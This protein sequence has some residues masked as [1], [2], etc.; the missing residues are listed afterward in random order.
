[1]AVGRAKWVQQENNNTK[2]NW[3]RAA[4]TLTHT[5]SGEEAGQGPAAV[6][7]VQQ[8]ASTRCVPLNLW[9]TFKA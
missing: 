2:T 9:L 7:G 1:M 6:G 5:A 3:A 8:D 4:H